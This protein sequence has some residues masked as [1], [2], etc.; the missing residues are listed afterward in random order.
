M[1]GGDGC[2]SCGAP[3]RY[4]FQQRLF[5]AAP[6]CMIGAL[7]VPEDVVLPFSDR[8]VTGARRRVLLA[9][10]TALPAAI[11]LASSLLT[12]EQV[13]PVELQ[14]ELLDLIRADALQLLQSAQYTPELWRAFAQDM[15]VQVERTLAVRITLLPPPSRRVD[16]QFLAL[17]L[18]GMYA[19]WLDDAERHVARENA[20]IVD[21]MLTASIGAKRSTA[22][23]KS[24]F[25]SLE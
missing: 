4:K 13:R 23:M 18:A 9:G 3:V 24:Y 19:V 22:I 8:S 12:L 5:C 7:R 6:Q 21:A 15:G 16:V 20:Q 1:Q 14:Q 2:H 17:T 10:F 11:D 25:A